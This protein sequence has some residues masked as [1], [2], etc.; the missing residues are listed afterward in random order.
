MKNNKT[1]FGKFIHTVFPNS[2]DSTKK[3]ATKII[4][5]IA[6]FALI[7]A[8]T[9]LALVINKYKK[10]QDIKEQYSSLY[11]PSSEISSVASNNTESEIIVPPVDIDEETG[12]LKELSELYKVNSNLVGFLEIPNTKLS[13]PVV[14]GENN[15][16]YLDHTLYNE[17]NPFGIPF[18]DYR[19]TFSPDYQS[20]N[21]TVYGH[22]AKDGSYFAAIKEYKDIEFYKKNPIIKFDTIYGK[23][24]YKI[25][26]FFMENV[27][28][29]NPKRF[30]YHDFVD[31][32]DDSAFNNFISN[33][34]NRSYFNTTVDVNPDDNI[35]TLSTCDT[36]VNNI[37]Y[38]VVLVARK[39]RDGESE[40]VDTAG[41]SKNTDMIMPDGWVKKKGK[42]NPYEGQ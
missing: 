42:Q 14:Q 26:G 31:K 10:G 21:V 27:R 25:I 5:W 39:I 17:Y 11:N 12:V 30:G 37:D 28:V 36:E 13:Y 9:L 23:G 40:E 18:A 2:K 34:E 41:A 6:S 32:K 15:K 4:C 8:L 3:K 35:L 22:S 38:R 29:D 20:T 19:A 33:V 7:I 24:K 1:G 16:F